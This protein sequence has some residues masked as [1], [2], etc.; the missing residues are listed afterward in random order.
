MYF[1]FE[2][3][4]LKKNNLEY[5]TYWQHS[6]F[7]GITIIVKDLG[8]ALTECFDAAKFISRAAYFLFSLSLIFCL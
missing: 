6:Q 7:T 1:A 3:W 8:K 2:Q 5:W 4:R